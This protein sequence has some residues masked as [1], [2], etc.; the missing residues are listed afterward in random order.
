MSSKPVSVLVVDNDPAMRRAL[1]NSLVAQAYAV[2]EARSGEEAVE[3]IGQRP[4]DLVL[5]DIEMPGIGGMEACRRIRSIHPQT[6]IIMVTVR[7]N[8]EDKIQALE[9]GADDYITKPFSLPELLARTRAVTRRLSTRP[10]KGS[11]LQVGDLELDLER[12]TLRRAGLEVHLSPIE[13]SLLAYLMQHADTPIEHGKL[14]RTIWGPEYGC[15]LEYLRTYI[16]RLRKKIENDAMHP[17][18]LLTVPWMGYRFCSSAEHEASFR[19][20]QAGMA[21]L[22]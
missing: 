15:E 4:T 5:L 10:A 14:L 6:G 13:F 21:S 1:R 18:Y 22:E 2:E 3:E 19:A 20:A 11:L 16:K 17:E 8:E 9:A 7:D 12:R